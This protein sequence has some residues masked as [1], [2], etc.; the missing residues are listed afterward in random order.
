MDGILQGLIDKVRREGESEEKSMIGVLLSLQEEDP[1][2]YNDKNIKALII[3]MLSAGTDTSS[4]TIE[5]AMS[6]LLNNPDELH[7]AQAEIDQHTNNKNMLQESDLPNLPYLNQIV[8]ETLRLYPVGPLL[9]PHES[10]THCTIG[11]YDVDPGT[12]LLVNAY[13][14][15]RDPTV[16][17]EPD[18]FMPERFEDAKVDEGKLF[19]FGIGRRRCPGEGLAR[20]VVGLVLGSLI[21][22]FE[23]ERVGM[24][25]VDMS[26]GSGLT[27]PRAVAL[28]AM[29]RPR[30]GMMEVLSAL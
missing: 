11:G 9:V 13:A 16:W 28:E 22:C 27:M 30:E 25:K 15:Q 14:I 10:R 18:K 17:D 23:W 4:N 21:Q 6:I 20:R 29:C 7:K 19:P 3:S 24:E 12:M 2:Y 26:E 1:E 8:T 5:W